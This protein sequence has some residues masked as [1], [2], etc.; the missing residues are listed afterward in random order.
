MRK[1]VILISAIWDL[2]YMDDAYMASS[3]TSLLKAPVVTFYE[4]NVSVLDVCVDVWLLKK[5]RIRFVMD[6]GSRL[7]FLES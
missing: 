2:A 4:N 6:Q 7:Y 5:K 3:S 1:S